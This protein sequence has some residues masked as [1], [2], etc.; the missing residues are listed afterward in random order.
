MPGEKKSSK[1]LPALFHSS[2]GASTRLFLV[3]PSVTLSIKTS[4]EEV[5]VCVRVSGL[6]KGSL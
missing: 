2:T 4:A 3:L 1:T 6:D 5:C